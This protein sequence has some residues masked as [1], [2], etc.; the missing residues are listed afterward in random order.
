MADLGSIAAV[1]ADIDAKVTTNGANENTGA[2]VNTL[3]Q[4]MTDTIDALKADE[5]TPFVIVNSGDIKSA[6]RYYD[7]YNAKPRYVQVIP[8][9]T[10]AASA[11]A[12]NFLWWITGDSKWHMWANGGAEYYTSADAV[13]TPDLVTTWVA[14]VGANAPL[15][16]VELYEGTQQDLDEVLAAR[17]APKV[18]AGYISQSGTDAPTV[19]ELVNELGGTPV[20]SYDAPG[21]YIVTLAGAFPPT[22][23]SQFLGLIGPG[24]E[25]VGSGAVLIMHPQSGDTMIIVSGIIADSTTDDLLSSAYFEI[26]IYP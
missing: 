19:V 11:A 10:Q 12:S 1:K 21:S 24:S 6:Y 7:T 26:K 18:Y 23:T 8:G 15:P 17:K 20:F 9:T 3:L 5:L 4:N 22:K 16:T 2:R 25:P 14:A 13:A